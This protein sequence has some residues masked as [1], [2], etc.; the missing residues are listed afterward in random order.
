LSTAK[1]KTLAISASRIMGR[2]II[3]REA[4]AAEMT[5]SSESV[6]ITL[7]VC[8]TAMIKA[9]GMTIGM[10]DGRISVA[11]SKKVRADWPLSV[12]RSMRARTCVV[13]T[14]ASVQNSA[15]T[16]T[17]SVRRSI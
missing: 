2:T 1:E 5:T 13:Q 12:T 8:A 14:I 10:I 4:P 17:S 16:K 11:I 15:A 6:F 3:M 7:S 9:N